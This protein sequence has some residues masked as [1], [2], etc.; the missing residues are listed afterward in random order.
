MSNFSATEEDGVESFLIPGP[1]GTGK[2]ATME[3]A[4]EYLGVPIQVVNTI[5]LVPQGYVGTTI[6]DELFSL[7]SANGFRPELY[8]RCILVFDE[9]DKLGKDSLE[10]KITLTHI[11]LKLIEGGT[12][13]INKQY[14]DYKVN[15]RMFN[16]VFLGA[17]TD[18]FSGKDKQMGFGTVREKKEA[19]KFSLQK[20]ID[21]GYFDRELLTRINYYFP[22][23]ELDDD[24]KLHVILDSRLSTFLKKKERFQR[25][26]GVTI[27]GDEEFA[28]G[29]IDALKKGDQS[30]RDLNN[31]ISNALLKPQREIMM[32]RGAYKYLV[33]NGDTVVNKTFELK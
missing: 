17:F 7:I 19:E 2:T 23:Y 11:F 26:Y 1:T 9:F 30:V 33:L 28:R 27:T 13:P 4:A 29:I 6:E 3:C 18:A 8:N 16:K 14:K 31:L 21:S 5:N 24:T 22:Y 32:H 20:L 25:E 15:T 12:F 10:E